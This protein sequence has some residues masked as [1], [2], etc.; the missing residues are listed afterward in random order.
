[1]S[2]FSNNKVNNKN[3]KKVILIA[4][5][6]IFIISSSY[7]IFHF[8]TEWKNKKQMDNLATEMDN[9]KENVD[10]SV[11][12]PNKEVFEKMA[13]LKEK[14][15]DLVGWIKIEDTNINYPVMQT[16]NNKYYVDRNFDR[17]YT[18]MGSLFLDKDCSLTKPTANLLIYGHRNKSGQMFETLTKYKEKSFYESHK[19]FEFT[20]L[21]T[22]DTYQIIAV[23]QSQIFYKNQNV[24]KFYFFKDAKNEQEF[25]NY[26]QNIKRLSMYEIE[27]TAKYGE[28][29]MTLTTCDYH[30]EDGRFVVVAKKIENN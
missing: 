9:V 2:K 17:E 11:Q 29:L 24:F 19:T 12:D 6:I 14:N 5:F 30:V 4:F 18:S 26:I 23:F 1:M 10:E 25:N 15:S 28:Q 22:I 27:D 8:A 13:E 21:D 3:V 20:T 7:L 16:T